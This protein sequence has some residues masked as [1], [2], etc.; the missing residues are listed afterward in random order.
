MSSEDLTDQD[1]AGRKLANLVRTGEL[2]EEPPNPKEFASLVGSARVNLADAR[3]DALSLHGRFT[4]AYGAAHSLAV[5]GLRWHGYR[6]SK[7]Y[8]AF[9]CTGHTLGLS[10]VDREVLRVCHEARNLAEYQGELRVS[11][12]TL[13]D[14]L[15]VVEDLLLRVEALQ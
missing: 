10:A 2:Q 8:L 12:A 5:A 4:L 15:R 11:Q 13:D 9:L 14:L 7:R 1:Q 3:L 6:T